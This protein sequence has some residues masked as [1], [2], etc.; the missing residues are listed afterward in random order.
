MT[1]LIGTVFVASLLGSLHC[2]GM[3]GGFVGF[4]AGTDGTRRASVHAAY[5]LGRLVSYLMLGSIAGVIGSGLDF[6]GRW[7][8]VGPVAALVSGGLMVLWGAGALAMLLGL[9]TGRLNGGLLHRIAMQAHRFTQSWP[10]LARALMIGLF[11]TLLPCGWLYAFVIAAAGTGHP[12]S[13]MA[14]MAVFWAGTLPVMAGMGLAVQRLSGPLRRRLPLLTAAALIIAGLV[15]IGGH[16]RIS[17]VQLA[18]ANEPNC[19]V[20]R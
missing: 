13:A 10:P 9:R 6:A 11:S 5:N 14:V 8:G 3:C 18:N 19:H 7:S 4:Y 1:A 17:P 16:L 20:H 15:S 2:A 12:L